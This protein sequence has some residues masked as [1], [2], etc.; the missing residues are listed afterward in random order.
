MKHFNSESEM[1]NS[2]RRKPTS[3]IIN[4]KEDRLEKQIEPVSGKD[5]GNSGVDTQTY[6][7]N[8]DAYSQ[9]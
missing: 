8:A 4:L 2:T 5:K 9:T 3:L 1:H 6:E 7:G